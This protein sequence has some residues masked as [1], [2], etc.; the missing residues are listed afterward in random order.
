M[1]EIRVRFAPSPT[2]Y[3]H[4]GSLRTALYNY[5]FARHNHGKF[6]L[7]IEDTD[8][9]RYVEGAVENLLNALKWANMDYDEG[10]GKDSDDGPF[11]QSQ[12]LDIYNSYIKKIIDEQKAYPCFCSED[13]LK[14]MREE[15]TAANMPVMYDGFCRNIPVN[16]ARKRIEQGDKHVI[17][18]K[19]PKNGITKVNDIIRGEVEFRNELIDDQV[20]IKSDGFPTYHFANVVDDHLMKISH[21]IRGE[22]WLPST[23]KHII[24][25]DF[26]GWQI[27]QYAHLPLL[28]NPDRSKLSKRQG[29]VAVED[30]IEKGYLPEAMINFIA[31]LGWNRGDDQELFTIEELINDFTLER[32]NKAGAVFNIEKLQWMNSQYI[33]S[34]DNDSYLSVAREWLKKLEIQDENEADILIAVKDRLTTF[35]DLRKETTIFF[36]EM[37]DYSNEAKE[38]IL[39]S[40]SKVV[41]KVMLKEM[42]HYSQLTLEIFKQLMQDVQKTTQVKGKN[43]WMPVRA[44]LTGELAGPELP[45]VI[46]IFGK[47]KVEKLLKQAIEYRG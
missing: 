29:D 37:A 28:L 13:R 39:K 41:F 14:K 46:D 7:R 15:Q 27:P 38:W 11:Y 3:V 36:R 25:Y 33:K 34:M 42:G 26:F 9:T 47:N 8:Q 4:V 32:I 1:S 22:E 16:E 18:M 10:P 12:R 20:L 40:E 19:T 35:K 6:I 45:M 5:L 17:R 30:Y 2:G 23:S 24:L 31:L 43:L 21:V 44:A